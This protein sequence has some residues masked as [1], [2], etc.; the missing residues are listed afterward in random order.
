MIN[1]I[2][3]K[4]D[5]VF[6]KSLLNNIEKSKN[7][8]TPIQEA[9]LNSLEAIKLKYSSKTYQK[10]DFVE[11]NLYYRHKLDTVETI[12]YI[13]IKDSGI[14]FDTD[15]LTRFVQYS[16]DSKSFNNKGT[17]RYQLL[18]FFKFVDV[19]SYYKAKEFTNFVSF[20]FSSE[21]YNTKFIGNIVE[22]STENEDTGTTIKIYPFEDD[23]TY[24]FLNTDTIYNEVI[25]ENILEFN[26]HT[27]IPTIHIHKYLDGQEVKSNEKII[28]KQDIPTVDSKITMTI[29]Y[30]NIDNINKKFQK[31]SDT[32]EFLLNVIISK[33]DFLKKNKIC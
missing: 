33:D 32:E 27:N 5:S 9:F 12:D 14:G 6:W 19:Y 3:T 1:D 11:I 10:D 20:R 29:H 18:H 22:N 23:K 8:F 24:D 31:N 2:L 16:N 21:F 26:L 30:G 7:P 13:E 4:T 17:G 28:T 15:N 25:K